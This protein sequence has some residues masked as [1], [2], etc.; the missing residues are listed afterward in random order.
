MI[1][2]TKCKAMEPQIFTIKANSPT[3][4]KHFDH[5]WE[6]LEAPTSIDNLLHGKC[7]A[8]MYKLLC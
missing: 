2:K 7:D 4:V 5:I 6:Q 1:G 8:W 3:F